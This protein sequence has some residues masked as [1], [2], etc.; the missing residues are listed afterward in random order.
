MKLKTITGGPPEVTPTMKTPLRAVH[1]DFQL[2]I[3]A[4]FH[5]GWQRSRCHDAEA[6]PD[7]T[8]QAKRPLEL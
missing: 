3:W 8:Q 5:S 2:D 7:H 4:S 1:L 6:E